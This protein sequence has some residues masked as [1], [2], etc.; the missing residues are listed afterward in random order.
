M[1]I[2]SKL[3]SF[4]HLAEKFGP[5]IVSVTVPGAGPILA[6]LIQHGIVVAHAHPGTGAEKLALAVEEVTTGAKAINAVKPGTVDEAL[7]NDTMTKGIGATYDA[8]HLIHQN[9]PDV[10]PD[11]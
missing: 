5:G 3:K 8:I 4:A 1:S 7:L 9:Q 11:A 10:A 6:G 2:G